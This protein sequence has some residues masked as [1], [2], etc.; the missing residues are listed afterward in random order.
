M[1]GNAL[2]VV[3][4]RYSPLEYTQIAFKVNKILNYLDIKNCI[5]RSYSAKEDYGDLD[6]L[7]LSESLKNRKIID[8]IKKHFK[9]N[10]MYINQNVVSFDYK[11][12]QINFILKFEK[13]SYYSNNDLSNLKYY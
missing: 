4:R 13:E 5:P 2:S 7:I 10:E 11:E 3:T 6:V 9:P 12:F 1:G 8:I